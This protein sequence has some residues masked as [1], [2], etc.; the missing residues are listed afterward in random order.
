MDIT[1]SGVGRVK[2]SFESIGQPL[3]EDDPSVEEPYSFWIAVV[4]LGCRSASLD[5]AS[6]I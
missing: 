4:T 1:R 3:C 5:V 2:V 6:A